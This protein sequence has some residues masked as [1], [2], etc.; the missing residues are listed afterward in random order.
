MSANA[1]IIRPQKISVA[2]LTALN[3][4]SIAVFAASILLT[5]KHGDIQ[6]IGSNNN[7]REVYRPVARTA[8]APDSKSGGWGFK[9][10][11]ACLFFRGATSSKD[12]PP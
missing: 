8:R 9:S 4:R 11:L 3:L 2:P 7:Y 6:G 12:I 5:E 10:L 1:V